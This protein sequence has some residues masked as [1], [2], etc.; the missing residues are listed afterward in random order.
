MPDSS[1]KLRTARSVKWS[2]IDRLSS[3]VVYAVTG[4]V[5]AWLL[6]PSE[7][8]LVGAVLVFQAFAS[9]II[10][11]GFSYALIQRKNPTRLDYSTV[12][13]FN[14]GMS[15]VLYALLYL[16][17][18]LIADCFQSDQRLIPLSRVM[19]LTIILNASATVQ[20]NQLTKQM[21]MRPVAVANVVSLILGGA[22]GILLAYRGYG[23]WAIVWQA[24]ANSGIK[25]LLLW[26]TS[27]WLPLM[28]F[29]W[30]ALKGFFAVGS[31]MMATS[32]LNTVF[33]KI[34][35]FLIGNQSGMASLGYYSQGDKWST[36]GISSISQTLTSSFLPP[37]SAAQDDPDRFRRLCSKMNRL[38]AYMLF[39]ILA[40]LIVMA[41]PIFHTIFGVKWD[42][43]IPIF[44]LLL[45]RGIFTVLNGLYSNYMLALGRSGLVMKM[46]IVRDATALVALAI[47][48]PYLKL[49]PIDNPVLGVKIMIYGQIAASFAAWCVTLACATRISGASVIGYLRDCAPYAAL[50]A[51][52]VPL[53]WWISTLQWHPALLLAAQAVAGAG[54]Y[55]LANYLLRS[56]IQADALAYATGKMKIEA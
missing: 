17:A 27:K 10:D 2:A 36:M 56:K 7:F 18:P 4:I 21:H 16:C 1:L 22:L 26:L 37:L 15:V 29:S 3:Q 41:T 54:L 19:F 6:S 39:P 50:T 9:I 52:I 14:L 31:G 8:G 12:L 45:V 5:L 46:E 25:S 11:S 24:V 35:Y 33:L 47:T 32:I 44:Q 49:E 13:W 43:A 55:L 23:A 28:Q 20:I 30:Q 51:I 42:L 34:Y 48:W 53:L 38:T 40:G